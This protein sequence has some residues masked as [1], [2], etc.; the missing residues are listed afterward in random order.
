VKFAGK[1]LG[2][3]GGEVT[4]LFEWV[5]SLIP[6]RF[7]LAILRLEDKRSELCEEWR[8]KFQRREKCEKLSILHERPLINMQHAPLLIVYWICGAFACATLQL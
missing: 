3:G 5:E 2:K 4:P 8:Y 6:V 7:W 1:M